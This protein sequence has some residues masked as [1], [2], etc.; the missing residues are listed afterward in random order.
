MIHLPLAERYST[1]AAD[2]EGTR[3][4]RC[5]ADPLG[6]RH[7]PHLDDQLTQH[8]HGYRALVAFGRRRQYRQVVAVLVDETSIAP[9]NQSPASRFGVLAE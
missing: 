6:Y 9:H 2:Q 7:P 4:P 5:L 3:S 1:T 8:H